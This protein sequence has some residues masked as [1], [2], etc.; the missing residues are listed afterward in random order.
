MANEAFNEL[1]L[2]ELG[3][4]YKKIIN[5]KKF[6]FIKCVLGL[7]SVSVGKSIY[8]KLTFKCFPNREFYSTRDSSFKR[9]KNHFNSNL[10]DG[11]I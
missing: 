9:C 1:I 7:I 10:K 2:T 6:A 8:H 11:T 3:N 4:F 5:R